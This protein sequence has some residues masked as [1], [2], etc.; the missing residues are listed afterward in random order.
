MQEAPKIRIIVSPDSAVRLRTA[1]QWLSAYPPDAEILVLSPTREAG[2]EFVRNAALAAGA[3]FG[4]TRLTLNQLASVLAAPLLAGAG[5]APASGLVLTAVAARAVHLLMAER[6]LSYFEPVATRPG[7]P[8]AVARTLE[9]LRMND[10]DSRA[11]AGLARGGPDLA[12]LAERTDRELADAKLADRAVV[13]AAAIEAARSAT[14][15]H[16]VGLPLLLLDVP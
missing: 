1:A 15:S 4:L 12:A 10:A 7:F 14:P 6:A 8:T 13:F 2:D 9:E 11:I 3:R 16:T 5:R